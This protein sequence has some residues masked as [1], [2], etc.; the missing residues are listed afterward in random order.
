[1]WDGLEG[2]SNGTGTQDRGFPKPM[3]LCL[4]MGGAQLPLGDASFQGGCWLPSTH[5][6]SSPDAVWAGWAPAGTSDLTQISLCSL[7]LA[8]FVTTA[9]G[10]F[11]AWGGRPHWPGCGIL[12]VFAFL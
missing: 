4:G 6:V 8:V 12:L 3:A 5:P 11:P 10:G 7:G 9:Q 1:M 2:L